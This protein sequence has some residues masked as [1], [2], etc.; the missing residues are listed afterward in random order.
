[1]RIQDEVV[2]SSP[3]AISP[4]ALFKEIGTGIVTVV[5]PG[6]LAW[7][8]LEECDFMPPTYARLRQRV[9][10]FLDFFS[11]PSYGFTCEKSKQTIS[12]KGSRH[13]VNHLWML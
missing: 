2:R 4:I 10:H 8:R 13:G 6:A 12:R 11:N 7:L 1:M 3:L 5:F 9:Q